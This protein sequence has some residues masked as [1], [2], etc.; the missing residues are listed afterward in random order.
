LEHFRDE[1]EIR[2]EQSVFL[3][4]LRAVGG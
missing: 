3:R 4:G 2:I 1:Y